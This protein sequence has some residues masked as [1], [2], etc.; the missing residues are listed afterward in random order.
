MEKLFSIDGP[1]KGTVKKK[2][3]YIHKKY[4]RTWVS[5]SDFLLRKVQQAVKEME[6]FMQSS[7]N[8]RD[9]REEVKNTKR[10]F[11]RCVV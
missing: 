11:L 3:E 6:R 7:E 2:N 4:N 10:H 8:H 9:L 1:C 5:W